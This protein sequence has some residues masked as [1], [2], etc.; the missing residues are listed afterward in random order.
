MTK[1]GVELE[2]VVCRV[3]QD[4]VR[5]ARL[6]G[7]HRGWGWLAAGMAGGLGVASLVTELVNL[8]TKYHHQL[9]QPAGLATDLVPEQTVGDELLR[10]GHLPTHGA[11]PSLVLD[12]PVPGA[13][14]TGRAR[15][16]RHHHGVSEE[17]VTDGTEQ[18]RGNVDLE[19]II[20]FLQ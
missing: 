1:Q 8:T 15:T 19:T 17:L 14:I 11:L 18:L 2:V 9:L 7:N 10:V 3:G 20:S 4:N 16:A 6:Q 12:D 13:L 5:Q